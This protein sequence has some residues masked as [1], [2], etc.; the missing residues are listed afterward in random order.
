ML[1]I[2]RDTTHAAQLMQ[3]IQSEKFFE[4]R[5]KDKVIQVDSSK[6]G[7]EE[8]EMIQRLLAV[9]TPEEPTEIVIHV[10]MLKEGWDVTKGEVTTGFHPFKLDCSSIRYQPV[11]RDL[12]IQYLRTNTQ[13]T[14]G[15]GGQFQYE[16]RLEDYLV[17]GL[18]DFDDISYDEHA[19]L[20]YDLAGQMVA[21]LR[22]YLSADET[23]NVLIYHQKQLAAFVHA[24]M[25]DHQW[26]KATDYEVVVTKG[27]TELK[28]PAYTAKEGEP[29]HDFR[30]TVEEKS[31]I[32]QML[33][34]GFRRCLYT[35]QK[36]QSD[37]ERKLSVILDRET[38]KW[39][40]PAKGQFQIFYKAGIDPQEYVPDFVAEN[41]A[42][43]YMLEPKARNE[44]T[45]PE[46]L[47]KKEAA[48]KW[49]GLASDHAL[50]NGGKPWK[51][52]LIPHDAIAENMTLAGLV[53]QFGAAP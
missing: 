1:I 49:C 4:G 12:L 18:I 14:L 53:T 36:F 24:Q 48:V 25:Q 23:R 28:E 6:T 9:E 5:Y 32:P 47:A 13:Q 46:V 17:R 43:I 42:C 51:Y 7:A 8:D 39:F 35:I 20:L 40:K 3:L 52:A 38:Q 45:D 22:S 31:R 44:M 26:E 21:H 16:L 2:A 41:H 15:F 29:I 11:E 19:D 50:G 27:F 10:N 33:F 37:P 30:E 34:G